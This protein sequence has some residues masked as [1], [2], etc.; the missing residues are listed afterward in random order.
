MSF[1]RLGET[2]GTVACDEQ[3]VSAGAYQSG[4]TLGQPGPFSDGAKSVGLDG[5]AGWVSVPDASALHV[6]D[7]F[8][9]EAWVKRGNS[10]TGQNEA[11]ASKQDGDWVLMFNGGDQL[12]LRRSTVADVASST[13]TVKDVSQWH[14][15]VATKSGSSV[16]LYID[17][18]DVTGTV[19]NQTMADN[20]LPLAIGQSSTSAYLKGDIADVA[21]Y[22]TVL[23]PQQVTAHFQA[24]GGTSGGGGGTAAPAAPAEAPAEAGAPST[25]TVIP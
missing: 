12:T 6:G 23:S 17:G 4:T 15:V 3:G 21:L 14:Y 22:N 10:G 19:S 20:T 1:W 7:T 2:S 13:T 11:I 9:I 5:S 8:S 18:T 24:G 25:R 16:H